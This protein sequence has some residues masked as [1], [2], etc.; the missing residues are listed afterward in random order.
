MRGVPR[1]ASRST[2]TASRRGSCGPSPSDDP[3]L[4]EAALD[5]LCDPMPARVAPG[6]PPRHDQPERSSTPGSSTTSS[7]ARR[8][9][10]STAGSCPARPRRTCARSSS[11][12]SAT[13]PPHVDVE[14][15]IHAPAVDAPADGELYALLAQTVRD[16]DPDGIPLPFMVPFATDAKHTAVLG[17]PTYGFSPL[18]LAPE[19]RSS[20]G[21][22]GS[23]S[24]SASTRSAGACPSCTTSS[25]ASAAE[26]HASTGAGRS[27]RRSGRARS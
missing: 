4:G 15:V 5:A 24:G 16:H 10:R 3:R 8:R 19:E 9:S 22:T 11:G 7:P 2:S 1:A 12:G 20:S 6:A 17:V 27:P 21:S 23:T 26:G 14:L 25:A 13:S 18:R